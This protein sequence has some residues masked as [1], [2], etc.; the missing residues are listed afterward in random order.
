MTSDLYTDAHAHTQTHARTE[1]TPGIYCI[2]T[3]TDLRHPKDR[4][5]L[6]SPRYTG[7]TDRVLPGWN[8]ES[9]SADKPSVDSQSLGSLGVECPRMRVLISEW[10]SLPG[11]LREGSQGWMWELGL[12]QQLLSVCLCCVTN[13]PSSKWL[14][15]TM[16][17]FWLSRSAIRLASAGQF[18]CSRPDLAHLAGRVTLS[19]GLA[20]APHIQ[21]EASS[22][23]LAASSS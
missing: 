22:R 17:V 1:C 4:H 16:L 7:N 11:S 6:T 18:P 14:R 23:P 21:Q 5:F 9:K 20:W 3:Q 19:S 12:S 15:A 10:D 2:F 8:L 13:H